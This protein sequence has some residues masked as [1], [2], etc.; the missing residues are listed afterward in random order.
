MAV[1]D[2]SDKISPKER[3]ELQRWH[4]VTPIKAHLQVTGRVAFNA[5]LWERWSSEESV[6]CFGVVYQMRAGVCICELVGD[7]W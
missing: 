5:P 3:V 6:G 2:V 7:A 1:R 4:C